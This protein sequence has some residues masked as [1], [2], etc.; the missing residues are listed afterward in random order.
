MI[1][2]DL[3]ADCK[4]LKPDQE[5]KLKLV[6]DKSY[7]WY[8]PDDA[9]TTTAKRN[10]AYDRFI[11]RG[12]ELRK[13]IQDVYI[14]DFMQSFNLSIDV[15]SSI[16]HNNLTAFVRLKTDSIAGKGQ[17]AFPH[18]NDNYLGKSSSPQ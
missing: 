14:F 12:N 10:C 17:R 16:C 1:L 2:G 6:T 18:R 4:K 7:H 15:V 3:N 11:V 13:R 9:D 8:I 5:S